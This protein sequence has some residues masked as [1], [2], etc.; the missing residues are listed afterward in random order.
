[1]SVFVTVVLFFVL[2][3]AVNAGNSF[4]YPGKEIMDSKTVAF[5]K[6]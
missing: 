5:F 3:V 1:M 6:Q 4:K 2:A